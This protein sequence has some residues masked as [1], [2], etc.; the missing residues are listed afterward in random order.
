MNC[1][2]IAWLSSSFKCHRVIPAVRAV[3]S[4]AE[5]SVLP[6]GYSHVI[7][8]TVLLKHLEDRLRIQ[9]HQLHAT[10]QNGNLR[11]LLH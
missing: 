8:P 11:P 3:L 6:Y 1:V 9:Y 2:L 7:P 10:E 5:G 4:T